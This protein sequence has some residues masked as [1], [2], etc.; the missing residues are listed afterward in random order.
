MARDSL[1]MRLRVAP[2]DRSWTTGVRN[3]LLKLAIGSGPAPRCVA[4]EIV[5]CDLARGRQPVA[6]GK[7][8]FYEQNPNSVGD[9]PVGWSIGASGP[10]S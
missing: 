10:S 4:R 9:L 7:L 6:G 2:P 3:R 1:A 5:E 8:A